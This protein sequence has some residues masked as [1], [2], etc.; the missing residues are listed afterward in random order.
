MSRICPLGIISTSIFTLC[1]TSTLAVQLGDGR[2]SF[3]KSPRLINAV[4]TLSTVRVW[5]AKYYFMIEL[6]QDV[7][8]P[9]Q[10]LTIQQ[11]QAPDEIDF[12]LE[13]T[14]AFT[15][16]YTDKGEALNIQ[17]VSQ[18]E[19]TE[20]ISIR[21]DPPIPPGTT[22]SVGLFPKRNPDFG[23]VYLFG[24]T[25]FPAGEKPSGLYLGVGRLQFND[26]GRG[27]FFDW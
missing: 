11:R 10:T 24:V 7:G 13:K 16:V 21:F 27:S 9:L 15:G 22:F 17:S 6:P 25:A 3:D 23:G 14:R 2:V 4:T 8:E 1:A 5:S 19:E 20:T 26:V 12:Y 18:D